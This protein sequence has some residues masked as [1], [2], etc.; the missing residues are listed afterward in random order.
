[1]TQNNSV[2]VT[3]TIRQL[4]KNGYSLEKIA[5]SINKSYSTIWRWF[6]GKNKAHNTFAEK[7]RT[8]L[9]ENK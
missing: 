7:L 3:R 4:L 6:R 8:L 5:V 2:D 9:D 1:M